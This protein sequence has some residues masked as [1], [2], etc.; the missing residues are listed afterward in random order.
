MF[1]ARMAALRYQAGMSQAELAQKLSVSPSAVGMYEQGRR[2][3]SMDK[4]VALSRLF[5]VSTDFLLT[6][7][8]VTAGDQTA[9]GRLVQQ[10]REK[11]DREVTL[12]RED[13]TF[14]RLT[15]QELALAFAALLG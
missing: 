8:P 4:V 11:S 3:P 1:G 12:R 14:T 2:E 9:L 15:V 6:G 10:V 5:E 13:G 7:T